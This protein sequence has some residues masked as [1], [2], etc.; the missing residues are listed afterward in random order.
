MPFLGEAADFPTGPMILA[1]ALEAP[2][3]LFFGVRTGRRRY[4]VHFEP[5]ADP[6]V[7]GPRRAVDL[8]HWVGR[9]AARLEAQSRAH[10]YNWFNLYDF[11]KRR[12]GCPS[13]SCPSC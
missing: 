6:V 9:Y 10:P 1:A 8:A 5:F 7:L 11:W 13:C 12:A 2:V 3:V 4:D